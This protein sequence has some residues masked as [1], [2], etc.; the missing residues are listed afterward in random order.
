MGLEFKFDPEKA[1]LFAETVENRFQIRVV[2][3][4]LVLDLQW[5]DP[6]LI[7]RFLNPIDEVDLFIRRSTFL[8]R[9]H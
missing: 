6:K 1:R 4:M 5:L 3:K 2:H 9:S 7:F 8:V